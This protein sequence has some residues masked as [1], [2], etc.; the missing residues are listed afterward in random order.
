MRKVLFRIDGGGK[1]GQ[2][3]DEIK[4]RKYEEYKKL[5]MRDGEKIISEEM[6]TQKRIG[7]VMVIKLKD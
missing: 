5:L 1:E 2:E 4:L 3:T 7:R 6:R